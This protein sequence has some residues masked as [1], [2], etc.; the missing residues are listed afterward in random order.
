MAFRYTNEPDEPPTPTPSSLAKSKRA[1]NL[2]ERNASNKQHR[3]SFAS[4][5]VSKTIEPNDDDY[6]DNDDDDKASSTTTTTTLPSTTTATTGDDTDAEL[7][8]EAKRAW[9]KLGQ[10]K[11]IHG[12]DFDDFAAMGASSASA[13]GRGAQVQRRQEVLAEL[14]RT[15]VAQ[16][17]QGDFEASFATCLEMVRTNARSKEAYLL[18]AE[19][20]ERK[21]EPDLQHA[22]DY[23]SLATQFHKRD[24]ELWKHIADRACAVQ[25][26]E[27]AILANRM[28]LK[29]GEQRI[30]RAEVMHQLALCY[31]NN[32]D[33]EKAHRQVIEL[34]KHPVGFPLV[35]GVAVQLYKYGEVERAIEFV[36]RQLSMLGPN[37]TAYRNN[38]AAVLTQMY[39]ENY[40]HQECVVFLGLLLGAPREQ[41]QPVIEQLAAE[42]SESATR[43]ARAQQDKRNKAAAAAADD[44]DVFDDDAD[45][46]NADDADEDDTP[47]PI[48]IT[49][50]NIPAMLPLATVKL[51]G[52]L[53]EDDAKSSNARN[54][55]DDD[56]DDEA[57]LFG[58]SAR[59]K[60][61]AEPA[62][63]WSEATRV[64]NER[65][66]TLLNGN[67]LLGNEPPSIDLVTPYACSL[68]EC[69]GLP[70]AQ[71]LFEYLL[72]IEGEFDLHIRIARTLM[73]TGAPALAQSTLERI[74][75]A[76]T[77]SGAAS[78]SAVP[79]K[80]VAL[81]LQLYSM[82]C[83]RLAQP[84]KSYE[85]HCRALDAFPMDE[86]V[87]VRV[88][89]E[90]EMH[91]E[92]ERARDTL[93]VLYRSHLDASIAAIRANNAGVS[94][95]VIEDEA[96]ERLIATF[97]K[98]VAMY[99]MMALFVGGSEGGV[100]EG[101]PRDSREP[102]LHAR[103]AQ[104]P[105]V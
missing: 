12:I 14:Q 39:R 55:D 9:L 58:V 69:V 13:R 15:A 70:V 30:N 22:L 28:I 21:P 27:T 46:D 34:I 63:T 23:L 48:V 79:P 88:A 32:R 73:E 77:A 2:K 82:C 42:A 66:V 75:E 102:R 91:G 40:L 20:M 16:L 54:T 72:A 97:P 52:L 85:L 84:L 10:Q 43:E 3:V 38:F 78:A 90:F 71:P 86:A 1:S 81:L 47:A 87:V 67:V 59:A 18:L 103:A 17:E 99:I 83:E 105:E 26:F 80:L 74:F 65:G 24:V 8:L 19:I 62:K 36:C 100:H 94:A 51:A 41:F 95:A 6:D 33:D 49:A 56:D 89:Q 31:E 45:D 76:M 4:T 60:A 68:A 98:L 57:A 101:G 44:D 29:Y 25:A 104:Q 53:T 92:Y 37:D 11:L 64:M 96:L 5:V 35:I 93:Y 61:P 7:E 50:R